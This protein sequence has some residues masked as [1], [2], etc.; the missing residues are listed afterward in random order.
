MLH[1]FLQIETPPEEFTKYLLWNIGIL[2]AVVGSLFAL[3]K[4]NFE[5]RLNE[6]NEHIRQ[7]QD[8]IIR[9]RQ[10]NMQLIKSIQ[11]RVQEVDDLAQTILKLLRDER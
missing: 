9:L 7:L 2:V 1:I 8:E 6:K 4:S 10:E 3:L 5:T 11:P